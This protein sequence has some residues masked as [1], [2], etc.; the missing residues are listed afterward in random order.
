MAPQ[1]MRFTRG[2]QRLH[3]LREFLQQSSSI[4]LLDFA[5]DLSPFFFRRL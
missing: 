5:H 3:L 1:R 2:Q 4:V